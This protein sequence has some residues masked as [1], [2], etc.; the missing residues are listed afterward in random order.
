MLVNSKADY[1]RDFPRTL[2]FKYSVKVHVVPGAQSAMQ[3]ARQTKQ[4][5]GIS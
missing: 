3:K 2:K 1:H 5:D 4:V